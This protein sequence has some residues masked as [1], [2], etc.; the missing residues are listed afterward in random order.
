VAGVVAA[1]KTHDDVRAMAEPIDD[2]AFTFVA[3]LS[4]DNNYACHEYDFPACPDGRA[5][6]STGPRRAGGITMSLFLLAAPI[7]RVEAMRAAWFTMR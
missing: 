3:P 1:L 2:L 6:P 4:A 7:A 5:R